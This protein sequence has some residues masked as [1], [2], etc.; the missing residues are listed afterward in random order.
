MLE[1]KEIWL[2]NLNPRIDNI[3]RINSKIKS[4]I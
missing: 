1:K 4:A 2:S 3:N